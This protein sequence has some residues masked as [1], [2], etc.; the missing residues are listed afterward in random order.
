VI[1]LEERDDGVVMP[2]KA[3]A[4]AAHNA[5]TGT[6][7]GMLKVSVTQ[8]PEQGKA[9]QAIIKLLANSLDLS[10]SQIMLVTGESSPHKKF[11]L[12]GLNLSQLRKSLDHLLPDLD[13]RS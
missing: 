8:A 3:R 1:D 4:G 10:K 6:H 12:S 13:F 2:V 7:A 5:I 9:N 11:L